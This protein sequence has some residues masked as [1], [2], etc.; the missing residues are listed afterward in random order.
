MHSIIAS[1]SIAGGKIH[2]RDRQTVF[3][4]AVDPMDE[5]WV[6]HE[7]EPD[8]SQPDTLNTRMCGT[9]HKMQFIR[10]TFVALRK[11]D[12]SSRRPGRAPSFSMTL[13]LQHAF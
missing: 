4:K 5:N 9:S 10:L 7:G 1:G 3:F 11:W 12:K 2:G 13:Y 8:M 6:D